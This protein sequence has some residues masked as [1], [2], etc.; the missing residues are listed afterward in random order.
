MKNYQKL[1]LVFAF[2]IAVTSLKFSTTETKETSL[3]LSNVKALVEVEAVG[4]ESTCE[5][6]T[7]NA[8]KI[9]LKSGTILEG[10]GQ[11]KVVTTVN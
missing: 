11:P 8:C 2:A 1:F 9:T 7:Q 10:V 6:T 4:E 5:A 3:S